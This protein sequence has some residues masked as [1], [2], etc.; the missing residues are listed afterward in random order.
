MFHQ[1]KILDSKGKL[2]K[3]IPVTDLRRKHWNNFFDTHLSMSKKPK[4]KGKGA[5]KA[6][7]YFLD[8]ED[9]YDS[10]GL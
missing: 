3:I 2:K 8:R 4:A 9:L 1:V 7:D 10:D 6:N 5:Q